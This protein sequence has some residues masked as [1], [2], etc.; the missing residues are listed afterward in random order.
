MK[1][2]TVR[3]LI[4]RLHNEDPDSIAKIDLRM[5]GRGDL[6]HSFSL[7]IAEVSPGGVN[8]QEDGIAR[9]ETIIS[10]SNE[11]TIAPVSGGMRIPVSGKSL[12]EKKPEKMIRDDIEKLGRLW[13]LQI[14]ADS[15]A[16]QGGVGLALTP[17]QDAFIG[18]MEKEFPEHFAEVQV[19]F[20]KLLHTILAQP[21]KEHE[22]SFL[23]DRVRK[24]E[25][26]F[27]LGLAVE[28][29]AIHRSGVDCRFA[30]ENHDGPDTCT[31][32]INIMKVIPCSKEVCPIPDGINWE[33]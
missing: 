8:T 26:R 2:L 11:L 32:P 21:G 23:A 10:L 13:I 16:A 30:N 9:P 18:R 28:D 14:E 15:I 1:G 31:H 3:E 12:P 17:G 5:Y 20:K 24:E 6:R 19:R 22:I 7:D 29:Y 33:E 27:S 25:G 4:L